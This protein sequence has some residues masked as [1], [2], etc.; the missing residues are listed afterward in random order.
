MLHPN[1]K[2]A[3]RV[4]AWHR[5]AQGDVPFKKMFAYFA[6]TDWLVRCNGSDVRR[7]NEVKLRRARLVLGL[8]TTF[9]RSNIAVF[10]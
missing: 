3:S 1:F 9:V 8:V 10:T 4:G 2:S 6:L 7:I 5:H